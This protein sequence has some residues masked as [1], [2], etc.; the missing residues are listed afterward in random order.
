[1]VFGTNTT[2]GLSAGQD[3]SGIPS[4]TVGYRRQEAVVMPLVANTADN[5]SYQ[6]P[7]NIQN[8]PPLLADQMNPCLL[9]GVSD[10]GSI[11]T[12]SVLASFGAQFR[13]SG[14]QA[15]ASGGLAQFFSTGI[16]AQNLAIRG[17]A[18]LVAA[19]DSATA[20][21][22]SG[23]DA[24]VAAALTNSEVIEGVRTGSADLRTTLGQI[25]ARYQQTADPASLAA[26]ID[27]FEAAAGINPATGIYAET[28][29]SR[30]D[31]VG[32]DAPKA[33]AARAACLGKIRDAYGSTPLARLQAALQQRNGGTQ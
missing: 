24:E 20:E 18:A 22:Y 27:A 12:Y 7:C 26:E 31:L 9:V 6:E 10:R 23:L 28:G 15:N 21:A 16:A 25:G 8:M 11:D 4:F 2:F 14:T 19:S 17:G 30:P 33:T 13:G 29:C 3:V 5:G 1:M 32:T